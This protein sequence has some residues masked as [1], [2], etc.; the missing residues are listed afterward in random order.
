MVIINS[1]ALAKNA[2]RSSRCRGNASSEWRMQYFNVAGFVS[3]EFNLVRNFE[4]PCSICICGDDDVQVSI[5][6]IGM[7]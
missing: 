4:A 2:A 1:I 7:L 6:V 5:H 3:L